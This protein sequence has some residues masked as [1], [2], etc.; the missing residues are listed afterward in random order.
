MCL[1]RLFDVG[2]LLLWGPSWLGVVV[3]QLLGNVRTRTLLGD[4]VVH[5]LFGSC[6]LV[7]VL[8]A[9]LGQSVFD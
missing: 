7:V 5:V 2:H 1:V 8:G 6:G 4:D 9:L 3:E